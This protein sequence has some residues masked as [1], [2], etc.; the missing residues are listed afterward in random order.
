MSSIQSSYPTSLYGTLPV[1]NVSVA[2]TTNPSLVQAATTLSEQADVLATMDGSSSSNN[3]VDMLDS[4]VQSG[5]A[6]SLPTPTQGTVGAENTAVQG[7]ID[8]TLLGAQS[9]DPLLNAVYDSSGSL[10]PLQTPTSSNTSTWA[11]IVQSDPNAAT[12]MTKAAVDQNL[13]SQ[14]STYA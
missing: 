11:S 6:S 9:S 5:T 12:A 7:I 3:A 10:Q 2:Q 1:P 4:F 14:F 13:I 8:Q